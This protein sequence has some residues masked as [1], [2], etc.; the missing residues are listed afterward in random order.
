MSFF[1]KLFGAG[2]DPGPVTPPPAPAPPPAAVSGGEPVRAYDKFGREVL[3]PRHEWVGNVLL[4]QIRKDWDN[5]GE[6][7]AALVQAFNDGFFAE[8][9]E[10]AE[11]LLAIDPEPARAVNLLGIIYLQ[12]G[13]PALAESVLADH[14]RQHGE[15]GVTLTNLA[16]ALAALGR[17]EEARSTLWHALE[18]SPNMDNAFGWYIA[19]H[20]DS[21]GR[22]EELAALD[23]VAAL[24][25]SWRARLW[26]ARDALETG[27][28]G[29][30]LAL[31]QEAFGM[32]GTPVPADLLVQMSGDLGKNGHVPDILNLAGPHFVAAT[33]GIGVG[34]NLIKACIDTGH[35][36]AARDIL[37]KLEAC[38]RPDWR[39]TLGFWEKELHISFLQTEEAPAIGDLRMTLLQLKGPLWFIPD[40]PAVRPVP[41]RL[42]DA[43]HVAFFG[44]SYQAAHMPSA[45]E[46]QPSD[47]PGRMSR[48]VPLFLN[49]AVHLH[50]DARTTTLVPW[51]TNGGGGF[52]LFGAPCDPAEMAS[53]ARAMTGAAGDTCPADF[54]VTAHLVISGENWKLL[55]DLVRTIDGSVVASLSHDFPEG[56]FHRVAGQVVTDLLAALHRE[57]GVATRTP[58][59]ALVIPPAEV[60]HYLF[61]A[62]Q[63]LAVR[64]ST[65]DGVA[66]GFLSNPGEI[67]DGLVGLCLRNPAHL[68][69]RI[70]L[71][72][73]LDGLAKIEPELVRSMAEKVRGLQ[74]DHPLEDSIQQALDAEF[75]KITG[76]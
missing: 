74:A 9:E 62:E 55:L 23:R 63:T 18:L 33:H 32:A 12:T 29:R 15:D 45:P 8:L 54:L 35:L 24:P 38:Q 72:R 43:P 13:R 73:T 60:D 53:Q 71:W 58:A 14:I 30:A 25:G 51:I 48:S 57:A 5:P 16:K 49:E 59:A 52:G 68:P 46:V 47:A 34:N 36:D 50:S 40:H 70:L 27:D 17:D 4:P 65:M 37:R 6:L 44:S 61:R 3:I 26:I 64:C 76:I 66:R 11:R 67:L 22:D 56:G 69:S 31:Y 42:A 1:R 19:T 2:K 20:R 41:P 21:G 10:A 39:D 28:R 7:A 75:G